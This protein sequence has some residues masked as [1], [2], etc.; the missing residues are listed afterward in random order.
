MKANSYYL[1]NMSIMPF[2][3]N[4]LQFILACLSIL[5][6]PIL[7]SAQVPTNDDCLTCHEATANETGH[8]YDAS[9]ATSAHQGMNCVDC[10]SHITEI[11]HPESLATVECSNCHEDAAMAYK[12]HGRLPYPGGVDVPSCWDCHGKHDI[13]VS[14]NEKSRVNNRNLATTCG[15]CHDNVDL[16][17][18]HDILVS[19]AVEDYKHSVHGRATAGGVSLAATC[20]DCHSTGGTAHKILPP[21]DQQSTINHFNI[22]K[23]CGKCH[24]N[25]EKEFWEGIHGKLVARGETDAPVCTDCHGEHGIIPP[26]DPRSRVNPARVA[27]ATCSPCH[28]SAKLNE[29]YGAP[30]GRLE[31][32]IDSYHGLKSKAGD[33]TVANC[34]SCHGAHRV[35]PSTDSTSSIYP[36]NLQ[37]TCGKCH[38]G[39]SASIAKTPIHGAPGTSQTPMANI[40]KNIYIWM[41]AIIIG[42]MV[43]HWL[44]DLRKQIQIVNQKPQIQRMTYGDVWQHTFLMV[45]FIILV[46]T[47]FSLRFSEAWWVKLTFGWQGGFQLRGLIHR[48]AAGIFI[49]TVI[50]HIF[51]LLTR[52]GR[53][54]VVDIFPRKT[55]IAQFFQSMAYNLNLSKNKPAFG[56]FSYIEKAEYWALVWGAAVMIFSGFFLWF[57]NVASRWF[58]KGF[59][60]VML[61][62]HY[63][64]AWLATLAILIW[65][66]YSTVFSPNVYPMNPSWYTG[67]MPKEIYEHEHPED[68]ALKHETKRTVAVDLNS[69]NDTLDKGESKNV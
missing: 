69:Q 35:L 28:E 43:I 50:W 63:Y 32:F 2:L 61:V 29:K 9:L 51:F 10:H 6:L 44:I 26:S 21:S 39:I 4:R 64:E 68:P 62:V 30:T 67:K 40:F 24:S 57:D 58:A 3:K 60:D 14:S 12:S 7:V 41:I 8:T 31:T 5:I 65:H 42:G 66:M 13:L 22:P 34:A 17:K 15:V 16:I 37:H 19:T 54:F 56:R 48:V 27:I 52:R 46:I 1:V 59:L 47:G 20:K 25:I 36:G 33:V 11:P 53:Q 49:F 55:D 45:T 23:T 18:K 38:P